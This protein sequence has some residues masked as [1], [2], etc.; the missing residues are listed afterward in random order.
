MKGLPVRCYNDPAAAG[1]LGAARKKREN[2]NAAFS[3][4]VIASRRHERNKNLL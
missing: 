3:I 4:E 2:S 1:Q